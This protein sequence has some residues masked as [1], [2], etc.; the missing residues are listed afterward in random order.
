MDDGALQEYQAGFVALV[1][2]PNVGK[3]TL[4]NGLTGQA[5][6]IVTSRPQT[7]RQRVTAIYST[8]TH[9]AIF[10]DTPGLLE[11]RYLLQVSMQREA[12]SG[13][14]DADVLV[15]VTDL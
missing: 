9:Q 15:Y 3:S 2:L 14:V 4:V 5:L 13:A 11:A 8:D 10:V 12:E 6:S 7:T 1:G